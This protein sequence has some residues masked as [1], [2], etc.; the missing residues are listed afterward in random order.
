[1]FT[2]LSMA[3][4]RY[5]VIHAEENTFVFFLLI[6]YDT[7]FSITFSAFNPTFLFILYLYIFLGNFLFCNARDKATT[8]P[9][10][11]DIFTLKF[12]RTFVGC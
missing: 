4:G 6:R 5:V 3:C 7:Q 10:F 11:S 2:S 8:L 1:M 12:A 9:H